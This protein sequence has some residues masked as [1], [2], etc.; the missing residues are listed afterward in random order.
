MFQF[1]VR[2]DTVTAIVEER[3]QDHTSNQRPMSRWCDDNKLGFLLGVLTH[4]PDCAEEIF[5]LFDPEAEPTQEAVTSLINDMYDLHI[6]PFKQHGLTG[7]STATLRK[8]DTSRAAS[9]TSV[10]FVDVAGTK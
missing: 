6:R 2:S 3:R 1:T 9:S 4:H 10:R 8:S 7:N 5:N